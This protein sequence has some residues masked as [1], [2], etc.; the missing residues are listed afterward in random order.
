MAIILKNAM[1]VELDPP[2]V[3]A[4]ELRIENGRIAAR[5]STGEASAGDEVVDCAGCVVLPGLVNGHTHLYSA[6]AVG[7]P[8]PRAAPRDFLEILSHIWWRLD[9][10]LDADLIETSA[11]IGALDAVRCGATTIID[12]HA[13]PNCIA[14]SLDRIERGAGDLDVRVVQCYETTDRHGRA[15]A[16]A[17][18]EEN[19]RYLEKCRERR[20]GRFA[21]LVGAH[22]SFT[23]EPETLAE[24]AALAGEFD[25]GIHIHVA[26][27]GAD[28]RDCRKRF[29]RSLFDH[30]AR[31]GV[32]RAGSILAHGTHLDAVAAARLKDFG[33]SVAHNPRSN[34]NNSVGYARLADFTCPVMLG[35][36]GIGSDM[37]T[38]AKFAWFKSRDA[39]GDVS[40]G[41]IIGMMAAAA[42]RASEALGV[43]VGRLEPGAAADVVVTDYLPATPLNGENL[44]GHLVFGMGPQIVKDMMIGGE[45][46]MRDRRVLVCDEAA[47]RRRAQDESA[48]LWR[49]IASL[50]D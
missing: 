8:A 20:D 6:L 19:R 1:R 47:V 23:L 25:V 30:L 11:R 5:G 16:R 22:A 27:D 3:A 35:T 38:E 37:L 44:F 24:L 28:E 17:G 46:V 2:S 49:Q 13:S 48:R 21:A 29:A 10:A 31:S 9:R 26:E 42:A 33:V 45:W 15:G 34:M 4:G 36:D 12:H 50:P 41:R 39:N 32:L 40:P 14:G 18:V 7:M 43:T